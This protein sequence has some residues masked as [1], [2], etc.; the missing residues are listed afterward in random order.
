MSHKK[1][2]IL[3]LLV[4]TCLARSVAAQAVS[5]RAAVMPDSAQM[6]AM[7][8]R[9]MRRMQPAQ[10]VLDHR[11]D[12]ALTPEQVPFLE[13][14]VLAQVDSTRVRTERRLANAMA[15]TRDPVTV[16]AG[17]TMTWTGTIDEA[18]IRELVRKQA[19]QSAEIQ[20][21]M[22]RDRH[23]VGAMLTPSQLSMLGRIEASDMMSPFIGRAVGVVR[24]PAVAPDRPYFDFQV[25]KQVSQQPGTSGPKYP[26]ALRASG[27]SGEVL[28]QFVVDTAG[29]YEDGSFKVLQSSHALFTQA[30]RDALPQMRFIPAEVGGAKVRQLVQ[31][32]FIFTPGMK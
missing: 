12:L 5:P 17:S 4:A 24:F 8:G 19:E 21:D 25:E 22:A 15:A 31:L 23:A 6:S 20:I 27:T 16:L 13:S 2:A 29:H 14:L 30:M 11:A 7:M 1:L 3:G 32:P 9:A 10:F 28:A 26:D 18:A